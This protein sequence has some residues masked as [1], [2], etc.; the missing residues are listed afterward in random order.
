MFQFFSFP[1]EGVSIAQF[2]TGADIY[3]LFRGDCGERILTNNPQ[4]S[5]MCCRGVW[6]HTVPTVHINRRK[7]QKEFGKN[8]LFNRTIPGKSLYFYIFLGAC[9]KGIVGKSC[10]CLF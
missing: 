3:S 10:P 1:T 7:F 9:L 5:D 4:A 2:Q 6:H 8:L